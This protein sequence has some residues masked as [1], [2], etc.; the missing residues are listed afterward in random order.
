MCV[1]CVCAFIAFNMC[2]AQVE[3]DTLLQLS[4]DELRDH[5]GVERLP[6]RALRKRLDELAAAA[7]AGQ[8]AR[9]AAPRRRR[10]CANPDCSTNAP[11]KLR[12]ERC[13]RVHYCAAACQRAHWLRH[14][15]TCVAAAR[16]EPVSRLA[17]RLCVGQL[18]C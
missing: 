3:G 2:G 17:C 12:C 18:E 16:P 8:A 11:A 13:N 5:M 6:L 4:D 9:A 7:A 15:P 14:K 10:P 1:Q